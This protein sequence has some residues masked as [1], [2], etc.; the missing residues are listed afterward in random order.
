MDEFVTELGRLRREHATEFDGVPMEYS[1]AL[2]PVMVFRGLTCS[3][4]A[5]PW[6]RRRQRQ[7]FWLKL[8]PICAARCTR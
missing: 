3:R 6:P 7:I 4:C 1:P 2:S 8:S 5:E